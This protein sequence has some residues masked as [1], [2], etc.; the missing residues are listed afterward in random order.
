MIKVYIKIALRHLWRSRL[1]ACINVAGLA[2]GITAVLLSVLYV[3]NERSFD[4]FHTHN[5]HLFRITTSMFEN[6]K[7]QTNGGTGQVQGPAF[8][9][10]IPE[11]LNFTRIMG[12]DIYGDVRSG[13]NAFRLQLLFVDDS[14]FDVFTFNLLQGNSKT[15][16]NS[17]NS[18]VITQKTALKFFNRL[19]VIGQVL[20]MDD[21]PS[22]RRL[23]KPLVVSG[24]VQN[25]PENSSVQFDILFPFSFMRLSFED[26]S[27]LNSYLGTFVVLHPDADVK[28]V[29]QKFNRI[30]QIH[31]AGQISER[32]RS[33]GTDPKIRYGLQSIT[34]IHLNPQELRDQNR[35]GGVINGSKPIYSYIFLGISSFILLMASI[36]FINISIA[37]SLKRTKE[38]GI[39][40]ITG[41]TQIQIMAGHAGESALLCLVAYLMGLLLTF[42]V[43]PVFN[44]LSG[45][46]IVFD[47]LLNIDFVGWSLAL[48]LVNM[49]APVIYPAYL[50]ARLNPVNILYEKH[51]LSGQN[52]IGKSLVVFQFA[53]AVS[54]GIATI[55]FYQQMRFIQTRDLGYNPAQIISIKVPGLADTKHLAQNFK[56]ELRSDSRINRLSVTGEFGMRDTKI[57]GRHFQSY[58]RSIDEDYFPLLEMKLKTGRNFSASFS[59]GKDRGVLVNEAFVKA[60]ALQIPLDAQ[61]E[62]DSHFGD[63]A[64]TIIGVVQDF[65]AG[66]LREKIQPMVL[67]SSKEFGG[68]AILTKIHK[69]GEKQ[70][71]ST[72]KKVFNKL[73]PGAVFDFSYLDE[74]NAR[75]YEQELR[76]QKIVAYATALSIFI[77]CI[78]LFAL[79][80]LSASQR[81]REIGIRRVLGAEIADIIYLFTKG[82]LKMVCVAIVIAAPL[83]CYAMNSW[84]EGYAYR[85]SFQWWFIALPA[86][87]AIVISVFTVGF[88]AMKA[89]SSNP[90]QSIRIE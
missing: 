78:G 17:V 23:E 29:E 22:A 55:V 12:G 46:Q 3:L 14:F 53:I 68:D 84:L 37:N 48:L 32:I 66:S 77:C 88:Q 7:R 38:T 61:L 24:V 89:A 86:V 40:K 83:A 28:M 74:Q 67:V 18:V 71:V 43:L 44:Q 26:Q 70:A 52:V 85:I 58:Y 4:R 27:W 49:L 69:N 54:L 30:H 59:S 56:N 90:V 82:F 50:L 73:L 87:L 51:K 1:Y 33:N 20:Q 9:A 21:D 60:A 31:S 6:G 42:A 25:P 64:L 45:K 79:G 11:I 81:M 47:A 34:D 35:E 19:D 39:R 15:A 8:K 72:L 16:L 76:W 5:P 80:H 36:N 2:L 63:E 10:Q 65:H 62:A 41:S 13:N 75:A 57:N